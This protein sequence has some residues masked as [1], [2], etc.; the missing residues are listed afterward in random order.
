MLCDAKLLYAE[1]LPTAN[2]AR[3]VVR[4]QQDSR[5]LELTGEGMGEMVADL[6]QGERVHVCFTA[7]LREIGPIPSLDLQ[8]V[9]LCPVNS[10]RVLLR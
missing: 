5:V 8:I 4:V 7:D 3:L 2:G 9:D 6:A 10:D 1:K